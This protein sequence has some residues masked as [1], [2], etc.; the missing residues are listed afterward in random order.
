MKTMRH[1]PGKTNHT[2]TQTHAKGKQ[3]NKTSELVISI[4]IEFYVFEKARKKINK[5][6]KIIKYMLYLHIIIKLFYYHS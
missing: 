6:M 4:D 3:N 5:F 2:Q 1:N